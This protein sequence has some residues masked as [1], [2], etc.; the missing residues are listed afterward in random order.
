VGKGV[1]LGGQAG[2]I[3]QLEIGDGARIAVAARV[4]RD[5]PAGD[6]VSGDPARPHREALHRQAAVA[7]AP[8]LLRRVKA[9]ELEVER[10]RKALGS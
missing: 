2:V 7:K 4:M 5:V 1:W 10:M 9:L 3:N 6:T 8:E